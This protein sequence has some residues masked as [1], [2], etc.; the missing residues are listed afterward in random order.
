MHIGGQTATLTEEYR[1]RQSRK[2]A[3]VLSSLEFSYSFSLIFFPLKI[4]SCL[5]LFNPFRVIN[6][7]LQS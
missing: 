1:G 4:L 3:E 6:R 7:S 2:D 5:E